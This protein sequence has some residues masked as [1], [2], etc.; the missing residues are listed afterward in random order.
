MKPKARKRSTAP[1]SFAPELGTAEA[2]AL[3]ARSDAATNTHDGRAMAALLS[4][5]TRAHVA[6]HAREFHESLRPIFAAFA[7]SPTAEGLF[8]RFLPA[9]LDPTRATGDEVPVT[10][11]EVAMQGVV[12]AMV[13]AD[14]DMAEIFDA[15]LRM[16][17]PLV[18]ATV[19]DV[20]HALLGQ[21]AE[22]L[23]TG[24]PATTALGSRVEGGRV[25][26][27]VNT[28]GPE[29]TRQIEDWWVVREAD[30]WRIAIDCTQCPT[31]RAEY[32]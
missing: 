10:E 11:S 6:E 25:I 15:A 21:M 26:L 18:G 30:G 19:D 12:V 20:L 9:A 31:T 8:R 3:C 32:H 23:R 17:N 2:A 1:L 14:R 13:K 22:D 24:D 28:L 4:A 7:R 27:T 5:G 29:G 16:L